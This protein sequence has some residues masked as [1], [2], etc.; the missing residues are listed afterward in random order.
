MVLGGFVAY[1][2]ETTI[3]RKRCSAT[4]SKHLAPN[5]R[6]T[7]QKQEVVRWTT[8]QAIFVPEL[9]DGWVVKSSG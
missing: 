3:S 9:P 8:P 5:C 7:L 1:H 4:G 2:Y 6:Q